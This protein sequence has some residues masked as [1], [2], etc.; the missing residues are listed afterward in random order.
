MPRSLVGIGV[1]SRRKREWWNCGCKGARQL[2]AGQNWHREDLAQGSC[3]LT[4]PASLS[5]ED[6]SC[7]NGAKRR[8]PVEAEEWM[9]V[10]FGSQGSYNKRKVVGKSQEAMSSF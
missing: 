5:E 3:V 10:S 1:K 2:E 8:P 7:W 9:A 4:D 6:L